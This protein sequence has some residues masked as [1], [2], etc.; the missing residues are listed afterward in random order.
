[1]IERNIHSRFVNKHDVEKNWNKAINFIPKKGEIIIYDVDEN[2]DYPRL[3]VGDGVTV[4]SALPFNGGVAKWSDLTEKPFEAEDFANLQSDMKNAKS[5]IEI[6]KSDISNLQTKV[7]TNQTNIENLDSAIVS[8]SEKVAQSDWNQEDS[9]KPDY[10]KNKPNV[11]NNYIILKDY[12]NGYDYMIM[13]VD[14]NLISRLPM[15]KLSVVSVAKTSY[16]KGAVLDSQDVIVEAAYPDGSSKIVTDFICDPILDGRVTVHYTEFGKTL[17]ATYK[18]KITM[19]D[20]EDALIDFA[21]TAN[22]DGTYT[23]NGWNGT[24]NGEPSTEL[25]IPNSSLIIL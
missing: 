12:I 21:Y 19:T 15:S 1:M 25:I 22:D 7:E 10:I 13:M 11:T 16:I 6:A 14:G 23:I 24:L 17:S 8:L 18:N 2:Y 5:D 9:T 4:V 20:V 3:K